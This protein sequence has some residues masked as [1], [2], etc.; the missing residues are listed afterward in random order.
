MRDAVRVW[1]LPVG[2]SPAALS[3]FHAVLD[4][5]E[6]AR[7][8]ALG[9]ASLR[10][11]FTVA[12]GALRV[13]AGRAAGAPPRTLTWR[14]GRC[15]RPELT[16]SHAGLHT[17]LSYSGDLVAVALGRGR[18]VGV[19]VQHHPP[20]GDPVALAE[21]FFHPEEARHVV[22]G[23]D[24]REQADRCTRLWVRKEAAVK[25]AGGRLWPNLAV[26]VHT[27][28]VVVCVDPPGTHRLV[29]VPTPAGYRVAVARPGDAP[30][31]VEFQPL[32]L[33]D[34]LCSDGSMLER[35]RDQVVKSLTAL[36]ERMLRPDAPITEGTQL[37]DELGLSSSLA[38]ELLLELEDELEIQIDVE[39]L[40]EDRMATL[41]DLADHITANSTPR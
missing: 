5:G 41:G 36:L 1:V 6:R 35:G 30:Y 19:D 2:A 24:L 22:E 25:S 17:S 34:V 23:A 33:A 38:L 40:D 3:R 18:P 13:L 21:R 27:G 8:A 14:P 31:P 12:H 26:P 32:T 28:D 7:A 16:G 29:D 4:A 39:D 20:G 37:M 15:G 10:D 11:R 9:T